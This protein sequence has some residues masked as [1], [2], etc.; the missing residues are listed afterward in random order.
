VQALTAQL[1]SLFASRQHSLVSALEAAAPQTPN[2]YLRQFLLQI[3]PDVQQNVRLYR[4]MEKYP[5]VF[6]P[7]YIFAV[8]HGTN[9]SRG[10]A[11]FKE[12]AQRWSSDPEQQCVIARRIVKRCALEALKDA[13]WMNRGFA[14]RALAEVG[15]R[16]IVPQILP[17]LND[18][19]PLVRQE[20]KKT[21]QRLGYKAQ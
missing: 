10:I 19:H 8:K 17:L 6:S 16:D 20:A 21:L 9:C 7:A 11:V 5:D 3:R 12:I 2:P 4:A 13:D 15:E 18:S 1:A 14:L